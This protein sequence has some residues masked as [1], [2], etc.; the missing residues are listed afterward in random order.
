MPGDEWQKFANLRLL[1]GFMF[2]HP[3]KKLLFMGDDFGQ[4]SEWNHES[5][6]DWH[7]LHYPLHA[8]L[9]RWVRDINTL[10]RGQSALHELDFNAAG[11]EWVDCKN[12]QRSIISFLRHG[13]RAED[14]ILFACNF[15]PVVRENYRV[16][17]SLEGNWKEV[18]NSDAPLYGGGGQGNFGGLSSS[19]LPIHGR[20]LSL[21]MRLTPLGIVAFQP[22]SPT[23][24]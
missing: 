13:R 11:F 12:S 7:L 15:T 5:S 16:G 3:G 9:S 1:Y 8:G 21:N 18:L 10:Y 24:K 22:E 4:W 20:P 14:Q 6:L 19:P 2:G 17:V 23:A